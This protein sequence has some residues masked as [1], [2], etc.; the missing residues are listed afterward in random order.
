MPE[1]AQTIPWVVLK[2]GGTSVSQKYRWDT[3]GKLMRERAELEHCRVLVVVS[4]LSGI[5]N[6]LQSLIEHADDPMFVADGF[7][8]ISARH[9]DFAKQLGLSADVLKERLSY[10]NELL[11]SDQCEKQSFEWQ[12]EILAQ[13]ELLSTALFNYYLEEIGINSILLPALERCNQASWSA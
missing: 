10:L 6:Q 4:A 8:Q 5:T 13:G 2:F 7:Q 12:A 3:I 9:T 11:T 1:S